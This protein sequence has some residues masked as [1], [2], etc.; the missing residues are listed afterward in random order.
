[1]NETGSS[2][3]DEISMADLAMDDGPAP[4]PVDS[5]HAL[6]TDP[7][8][9][10]DRAEGESHRLVLA[11]APE[12]DAELYTRMLREIRSW[13]FVLM[14]WGALQLAGSSVSWGTLLLAVGLGS[15]YFREAA[16]FVVYGVSMTWAAI[17]NI[18]GGDLAGIVIGLVQIVMAFQIFRQFSRFHQMQIEHLAASA[19]GNQPI[20]GR[21]ARIFPWAGGLLGILSMGCALVTFLGGI[22]YPFFTGVTGLPDF[23]ILLIEMSVILGVLSMALSL[24]A[25]LS[26][27]RHRLLSVCGIATGAVGPLIMLSLYLLAFLL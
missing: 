23:W 8:S 7:A 24:A 11:R 18:L 9:P 25:L 15:F 12:N 5:M 4:P 1:M 14:F 27:Y 6:E 10:G 17:L 20:P 13:G 26:G 19:P 21:S 16:I 2:I 3:Q 22:F